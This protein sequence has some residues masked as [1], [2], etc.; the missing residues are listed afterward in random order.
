MPK[1]CMFCEAKQQNGASPFP[2]IEEIEGRFGFVV[3]M[4]KIKKLK[5]HDA[6]TEAI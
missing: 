2:K 5:R 4:K 6:F 1:A 3:T